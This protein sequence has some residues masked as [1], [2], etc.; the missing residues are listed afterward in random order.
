MQIETIPTIAFDLD[1][2]GLQWDGGGDISG[3]DVDAADETIGGELIVGGVAGPA[4]AEGVT[5]LIE[6]D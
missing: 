3:L 6:L 1:F 4:H 5:V 2:I